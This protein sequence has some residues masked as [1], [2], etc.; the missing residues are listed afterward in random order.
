MIGVRMLVPSCLTDEE[1]IHGHLGQDIQPNA[2]Y[3]T[4]KIVVSQ[5]GNENPF[6]LRHTLAVYVTSGGSTP[7]GRS[8]QFVTP[9]LQLRGTDVCDI[10]SPRQHFLSMIL[11]LECPDKNKDL[12]K[13]TTKYLG[14]DITKT[15]CV[16]QAS[17]QD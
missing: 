8:P 13:E 12:F 9:N 14:H 10:S 7:C 2:K 4:R 16:P 3:A 15:L 11:S 5:V 1:M 17:L 6:N